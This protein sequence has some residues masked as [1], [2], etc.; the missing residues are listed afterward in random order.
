MTRSSVQVELSA[1]PTKQSV[2]MAVKLNK[3]G[4]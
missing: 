3:K 1:V 2:D 4:T